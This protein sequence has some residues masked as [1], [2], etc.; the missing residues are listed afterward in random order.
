[1]PRRCIGKCFFVPGVEFH[2][3]ERAKTNR[4]RGCFRVLAMSTRHADLQCLIMPHT[5]AVDALKRP[6]KRPNHGRGQ[7]E[8]LRSLRRCAIQVDALSEDL[9]MVSKGRRHE[10]RHSG[11][12]PSPM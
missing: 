4:S 6:G 11:V 2:R 10:A 3:G 8:Q 9:Y 12:C 5:D 1:M 7:F